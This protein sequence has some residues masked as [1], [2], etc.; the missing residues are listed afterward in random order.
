MQTLHMVLVLLGDFRVVVLVI[1]MEFLYIL[2]L[3]K[4]TMKITTK[5]SGCPCPHLPRIL[6]IKEE[7]KKNNS[8]PVSPIVF[9]DG[10][11]KYRHYNMTLL[12]PSLEMMS[13][14][15]N[16]PP[17]SNGNLEKPF[18]N[19]QRFGNFG[20]H[21][22]GFRRIEGIHEG[23]FGFTYG[24]DVVS[25][26][27]E[28]E[29]DAGFSLQGS[30]KIEKLERVSSQEEAGKTELCNKLIVRRLMLVMSV[31]GEEEIEIKGRSDVEIE[32]I[33]SVLEGLRPHVNLKELEL[34]V[35]NELYYGSSSN[36]DNDVGRRRIA[37]PKLEHLSLLFMSEL[38]EWELRPKAD[39]ADIVV[40]PSPQS[41]KLEDCTKLEVLPQHLATAPLTHPYVIG[42]RR[43]KG[44]GRSL[45]LLE[46]F[47]L[48]NTDNF[49]SSWLPDLPNLKKFQIEKLRHETLPDE[50]WELLVELQ[51]LEIR[52]CRELKSLPD[53]LRH[54]QS[55]EDLSVYSCEKLVSALWLSTWSISIISCLSSSA[56]H[57]SLFHGFRILMFENLGFLSVH[58]GTYCLVHDDDH[59]YDQI[60]TW[61]KVWLGGCGGVDY[62]LAR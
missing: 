58:G 38:E 55:L 53:G 35:G 21:G 9:S 13:K 33:D 18:M 34:K 62:L 11:E 56:E 10:S 26:L 27:W 57:L 24:A 45:T 25:S 50:G 41:L 30:L 42:C 2:S 59:V 51:K 6:T 46:D 49:F 1:D 32:R 39:A 43:I 15:G 54:L 5:N 37:F 16:G 44:T 19:P 29:E 17:L 12:L 60:Y 40:M 3:T 48:R 8:H 61:A 28:V 31:S 14:D 4:L 7:M 20:I 52:Q 36:D 22:G 47:L 23:V